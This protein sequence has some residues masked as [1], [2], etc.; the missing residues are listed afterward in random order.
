MFALA[1]CGKR[2]PDLPGVTG[3]SE[4]PFPS[5]ISD[6]SS[7][8]ARPEPS[9]LLPSLAVGVVPLF[10]YERGLGVLCEGDIVRDEIS[11]SLSSLF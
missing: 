8:P 5:K 11:N 3:A 2:T 4:R 6:S 9:R 1:L 10:I 7:I